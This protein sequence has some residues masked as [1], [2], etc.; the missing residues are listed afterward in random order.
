MIEGYNRVSGA[1][2]CGY[3]SN[4]IVASSR[5]TTRNQNGGMSFSERNSAAG[6]AHAEEQ[7]GRAYVISVANGGCPLPCSDASKDLGAIS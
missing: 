7:H 4:D 5:H 2:N 1:R 6:S 3:W